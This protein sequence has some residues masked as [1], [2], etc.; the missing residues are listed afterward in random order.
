MDEEGPPVLQKPFGEQMEVDEEDEFHDPENRF[1]ALRPRNKDVASITTVGV[2]SKML[3]PVAHS[4]ISKVESKKCII[5]RQWHKAGEPVID[6]EHWGSFSR[7]LDNACYALRSI[8]DPGKMGTPQVALVLYVMADPK[9]SVPKDGQFNLLDD[10]ECYK[11]YLHFP[12]GKVERYIKSGDKD[13]VSTGLSHFAHCRANTNNENE[14]VL[15]DRLF[16]ENIARS[17]WYD[18]WKETVREEIR[19]AG[20]TRSAGIRSS[21]S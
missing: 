9:T 11:F 13:V 3:P 2:K 17:Q 7:K 20:S 14:K 10:D 15:I 18:G 19:D 4:K 12:T 6:K 21:R 1:T 5:W 8:I 16:P